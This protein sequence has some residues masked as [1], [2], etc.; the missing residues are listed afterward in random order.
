MAA[1]FFGAADLGDFLAMIDVMLGLRLTRGARPSRPA[2]PEEKRVADKSKHLSQIRGRVSAVAGGWATRWT[3]GMSSVATAAFVRQLPKT[4]THL[5]LEGALPYELLQRLDPARFAH[6]P[7]SWAADFRFRSFTEFDDLIIGLLSP[8]FVSAA[9]YHE[10]ATLVFRRLAEQ[11]VRYVETSFHLPIVQFIGDRGDEILQAIHEAAP[12]GLTVRV[13]AGLVRNCHTGAMPA[14]IADALRWRWLA[15]FDLHGHETLPL[16]D[17][18]AEVWRRARDAGKET[19]AHAGEFGG[20][21][22]VR[23]AVERLGVRRIQ[24][25][26]RAVEDPAV[27]ALLVREGV[28]LDITPQSNVKLGVV[29]SLR[30][31]PLRRLLAAGVRCTVSTDDPLIFGHTLT[32]EYTALATD[33]GFTPA[34]LVQVA[35]NGFLAGTMP[36]PVR[37]DALAE[38]AGL[39]RAAG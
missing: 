19:K 29:P 31:H 23:V 24:H 1:V 7:A 3:R 16:E 14:V 22:N 35:R 6:P 10:A 26:V 8:W 37:R 27:V 21:E 28:T 39:E 36:E 32:D 5:H 33:A 12:P 17:W 13:F 25:G 9:R 34:E 18:T 15:G 20:A 4:E 38:L 2:G 11:N 30:E